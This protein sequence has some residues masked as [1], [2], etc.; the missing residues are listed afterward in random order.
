MV[1]IDLQNSKRKFAFNGMMD[2][3]LTPI[4]LKLWSDQL[5]T[6]AQDDKETTL[7]NDF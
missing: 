2:E 3:H 6:T 4:W 1:E 5:I 7:A